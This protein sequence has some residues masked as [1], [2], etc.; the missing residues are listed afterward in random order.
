MK[1]VFLTLLLLNIL[2]A[3]WQLQ[4]VTPTPEEGLHAPIAGVESLSSIESRGQVE[5]REGAPQAS[6]VPAV[7][8][9]L[10]VTLG[11]FGSAVEAEKL[12]QRLLVLGVAAELKTREVVVGT[13]YW[14]VMPV[15]G[16]ERHA[17]LQLSALQEQGVDGFLISR[18]ELAGQLSLGLFAREEYA[19]LRREQLRE[20]GH[21]VDLHALSKTEQQYVVEVDSKARRLVDQAMLSRLRVDFPAL[22][23]QYQ[24]CSG[25]ANGAGIP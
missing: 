15:V 10:C 21:E 9:A 13:D 18:G 14:L 22:Q 24:P 11:R 7:A 3:L 2:Y 6:E 17:V 12:R 1:Y 4:V 23:H 8:S 19:Q 5:G 20:L 25:V 16:G